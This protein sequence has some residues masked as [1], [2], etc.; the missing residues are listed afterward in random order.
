MSQEFLWWHLLLNRWILPLYAGIFIYFGLALENYK[1]RKNIE[2]EIDFIA[3]RT[4]FSD[5][6][7]T[8]TGEQLN[9]LKNEINKFNGIKGC[10]IL[11]AGTQTIEFEAG[12]M[13]DLFLKYKRSLNT[14]FNDFSQGKLKNRKYLPGR[15]LLLRII[16]E[17]QIL[18]INLANAFV[19]YID[20]KR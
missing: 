10:G 2:K 20:L 15:T 17:D 13:S 1:R 4:F 11:K 5:Y 16:K 6:N 19:P 7:Q 14:I 18:V 3:K 12:E 8:V 9:N